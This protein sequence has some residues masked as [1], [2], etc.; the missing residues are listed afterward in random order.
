MPGAGP[1]AASFEKASRRAGPGLGWPGPVRGDSASPRRPPGR[2]HR[3]TH[4]HGRMTTFPDDRRGGERAE[5][6]GRLREQHDLG[7][8]RAIAVRI[9]R[10]QRQTA[11]VSS[12][13]EADR[14]DDASTFARRAREPDRHRL[15][16]ERH[17]EHRPAVGGARARVRERLSVPGGVDDRREKLSGHPLVCP[18]DAG[19]APNASAQ[20]LPIG[21]DGSGDEDRHCLASGAANSGWTRAPIG[22]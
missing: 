17:D 12:C 2:R 20:P 16:R 18:C 21:C 10:Q 19:R 6:F 9:R 8:E 3:P 13:V 11:S 22:P 7:H 15:G 1:S 14:A 4:S 5:P